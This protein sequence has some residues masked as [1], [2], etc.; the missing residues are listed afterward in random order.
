MRNG[1]FFLWGV[2]AVLAGE[3]LLRFSDEGA[4]LLFAE[5]GLV[6]GEL[7]G[8]GGVAAFVEARHWPRCQDDLVGIVE[9][10][11]LDVALVIIAGDA[12][13]Q[14]TQGLVVAEG[15]ERIAVVEP[16]LKGV[17]VI[18]DA[19]GG[20]ALCFAQG[21]FHLV[22]SGGE[23]ILIDAVFDEIGEGVVDDAHEVVALGGVGL[24]GDDA[25]GDLQAVVGEGGDV[26]TDASGEK[27]IFHRAGLGFDEHL[28]EHLF[29]EDVCRL[30]A[31]A[32]GHGVGEDVL[33]GGLGIRRDGIEG[34]ELLGFG[35]GGLP[36]DGRIHL[37]AVVVAQIFAV[38]VF[39]EMGDVAVAVDE[40]IAVG[41]MVESAVEIEKSFIRKARDLVRI[42]A[43]L[44]AV[45]GLGIEAGEDGVGHLGI[46]AGEG[47][48]HFIVDD[49]AIGQRI[50]WFFDVE[51][52]ALLQEDLLAVVDR[53][54]KNGVEVD[55]HEV[56][57]IL[58]I[59]AGH[60]IDRLIGE[61]HGVEEGGQA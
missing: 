19:A 9:D 50:L 2:L 58:V 38:D 53:R 42:A 30:L 31:R 12:F 54:M 13:A 23:K 59:L 57:E 43:A 18:D 1:R 8:D 14:H 37:G 33:A 35:E 36:G 51:M 27:R 46:G 7:I 21:V 40:D 22:H 11:R 47:A 16:G 10:A 20:V 41:R 28:S 56:V 34:L 60:R 25:E 26:L 48:A 24:L 5:A 32:H 44:L 52:P 6:G 15:V 3:Q 49:A 55:V 39:E 29:D 4:H 17:D 61:G 45:D